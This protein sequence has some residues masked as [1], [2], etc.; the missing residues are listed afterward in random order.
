MLIKYNNIIMNPIHLFT[1]GYYQE[2]LFIGIIFGVI[3]GVYS[4]FRVKYALSD[5]GL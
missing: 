4:Y 2:Y 3:I 1:L 5:M